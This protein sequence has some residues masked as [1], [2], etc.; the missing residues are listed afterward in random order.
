MGICECFLSPLLCRI[1]LCVS[2]WGDLLVYVNSRG[3]F[4]LSVVRIAS[5]LLTAQ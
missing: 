1:Y 5:L 3:V 2:E 4:F